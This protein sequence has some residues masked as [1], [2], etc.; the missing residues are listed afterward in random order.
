MACLQ[1]RD[2]DVPEV[3]EDASLLIRIVIVMPGLHRL[4]VHSVACQ[5]LTIELNL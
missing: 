2:S 4:G 3:I 1:D 5:M